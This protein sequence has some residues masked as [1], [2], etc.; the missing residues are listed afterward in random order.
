VQRRYFLVVWKFAKC[1]QKKVFILKEYCPNCG[2]TW[3]K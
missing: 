3:E 2:I 1:I